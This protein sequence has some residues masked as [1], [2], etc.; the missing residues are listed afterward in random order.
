M[1]RT[2]LVMLMVVIIVTPCFAQEIGPEGIFSL[3]GT[4]WVSTVL[5]KSPEWVE[6]VKHEIGF[7]NGQVYSYCYF[8]TLCKPRGISHYYDFQFFSTFVE[9]YT[10]HHVGFEG[11]IFSLGILYPKLGTGIS[12]KF[13]Y[14]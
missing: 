1:K 13:I 12:Y 6:G 9:F 10:L 2:I 5:V 11:M 7:Y 8:T 3:H 14:G 4:K